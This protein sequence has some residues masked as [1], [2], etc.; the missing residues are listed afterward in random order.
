MRVERRLP[1]LS[2]LFGH[3]PAQEIRCPTLGNRLM[4][5]PISA[6]ITRALSSLTPGMLNGVAHVAL[7]ARHVLD[8][9]RVGQ[10][11]LEVAVA[12]DVPDRLPVDAGRLH[13]D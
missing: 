2:S 5:S 12:Q 1:A 3:R 11:Q 7:A 13:G 4:S 9:P 8:V 6:T 10:H